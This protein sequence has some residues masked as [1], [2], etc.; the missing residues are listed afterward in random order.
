MYSDYALM[1]SGENPRPTKRERIRNR[2]FHKFSSFPS[3]YGTGYACVGCARC[4]VHCPGG[5]EITQVIE[6]ILAKESVSE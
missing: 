4:L 6:D 2:Y 1:A 5:T 3:R